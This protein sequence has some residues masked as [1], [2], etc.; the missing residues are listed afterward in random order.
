MQKWNKNLHDFIKV[1]ENSMLIHHDHQK[2]LNTND[3]IYHGDN[4]YGVSSN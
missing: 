1:N 2:H 3:A 4:R